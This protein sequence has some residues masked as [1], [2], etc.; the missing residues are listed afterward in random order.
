MKQFSHD[1][2]LAKSHSKEKTM[3]PF[4]VLRIWLSGFIALG[5][6][7]VG[8][9]LF[10]DWYYYDREREQ[11]YW[12]IG[13]TA[14]AFG[15]QWLLR[16]FFGG[17]SASSGPQL[18]SAISRRIAGHK[19]TEL[20]LNVY[21]AKRGPVFLL[22]H[23]WSLNHSVWQYVVPVLLSRGEV[24]VWDLRGL[25]KSD[26]ASDNDYSIEAMAHDLAAVVKHFNDRPIVLVGHSIGGMISQ[27]FCRLHPGMLGKAVTE[28]VLVET[29]YTNPLKTARFASVWSALQKP[30]IE[31]LLHLT[32]WFSPLVRLMN[33]ASYL[34]GNMHTTTRFTSFSG[35]QTWRQLDLACR[36]SSFASPAVVA[37]G[38]LAMLLFDERA[39]LSSI[40]IPTTVIGGKN[41]RLTT[42]E[43][44]QTLAGQIP[45][46]RFL[47]LEPA[48]HL[49]LLERSEAVADEI[50]QH[51][52]AGTH[53]PL[54]RTA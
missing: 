15:G 10:Y 30:V 31:P 9:Y 32:V 50:G 51:G 45:G 14:F 28:M 25:G 29:T 11:L 12:A 27:T 53:V 18:P 19:G 33:L 43:A 48:G 17:L 3:L 20:H 46:G 2:T 6:I 39:T 35:R 34:N 7:G 42:I 47:P 37:R 54:V 23:G 44:N 36:L 41:D 26:K 21:P 4:S 22:T 52:D 16:P 38:M 8:G 5:V 40:P 1:W 13:L 49:S 24:A